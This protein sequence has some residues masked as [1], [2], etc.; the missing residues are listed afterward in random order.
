MLKSG[1]FTTLAVITAVCA[2]TALVFNY[3]E[4]NGILG[5]DFYSY[6]FVNPGK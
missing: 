1:L 6:L 4:F 3:L 2:L 5:D